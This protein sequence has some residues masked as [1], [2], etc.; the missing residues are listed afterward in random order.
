MIYYTTSEG[1]KWK[2]LERSL[3]RQVAIRQLNHYRVSDGVLS[4]SRLTFHQVHSVL[5]ND[6]RIWDSHFNGYRPMLRDAGRLH[7]RRVRGF[8]EIVRK[9]VAEGGFFYDADLSKVEF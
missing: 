4:L 3:R 7:R 9:T 8:N 2:P 6:G 1:G 5:F